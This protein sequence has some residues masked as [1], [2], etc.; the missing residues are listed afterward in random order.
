MADGHVKIYDDETLEDLG[1]LPILQ[2]R[3]GVRMSTDAVLLAHFAR[4]PPGAHVL[5]LG[6]GGGALMLLL[7]L[8]DKCAR[9]TGV[10]IQPQYADMARRSLLLGG[11]ADSMDVICGDLRDENLL[12]R[13][14]F[15]AVICNPPYR[16]ADEGRQSADAAR[17]TAYFEVACTLED[18]V[19]AA[20]RA[21][22]DKGTLALCL[23]PARLADAMCAMRLRGVEPKRARA[24][25]PVVLSPPS[26]ML[27]EGRRGA[28]PG[29]LF[30]KPLLLYD[31]DGRKTAEFSAMYAP[32]FCGADDVEG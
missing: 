17:R 14:A 24:V 19:S 32:E 28:R 3:A 10:E 18:A 31:G 23:R 16:R 30:E 6:C 2:K 27:I 5:D 26:L 13:E 29:L 9:C 1:G 4:T 20:A 12:P 22:R 15:D 8:W 21:L 11:L 7:R 25:F